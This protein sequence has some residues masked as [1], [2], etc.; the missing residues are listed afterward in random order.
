MTTTNKTMVSLCSALDSY[1]TTLNNRVK[2]E[3]GTYL[4]SLSGMT[5]SKDTPDVQGA[6]VALN[7]Q[8]VRGNVSSSKLNFDDNFRLS[9]VALINNVIQTARL[10]NNGTPESDVEVANYLRDLIVLSFQKRAI[11]ANLGGGER[12]LSYWL[13]IRLHEDF[14][15]TMET[16]LEEMPNYGSWLDLKKMYEI[17]SEDIKKLGGIDREKRMSRICLNKKIVSIWVTQCQLDE[18]T[19][20]SKVKTQMDSENMTLSLNFKWIPKPKSA[21]DRKYKVA[22]QIAKGLYPSLYEVNKHQAVKKYRK[23]STRG[24]AAINTT[25]RLMTS[26]QFSK[27]NFRLVPGRCLNKFHRAWMD[28]DKN[29][30]RRHKGNVDRDQCIENYMAFLELVKTGKVSAKGK[31]MFIHEIVREVR[32]SGGADRIRISDPERYTLLEAQ[33]RDHVESFREFTDVSGL[34]DSVFMADV[35]GSMDGDPL[36]VAVGVTVVGSSITTGPYRNKAITFESQPR[37]ITLEYPTS[38]TVW[39]DGF[40]GYSSRQFPIGN[41]WDSSRVG[42]ELDYLEKITVLVHAGWGGSTNFLGAVNLVYQ[43]AQIAGCSMPKRIICITDMQWDA[44][45]Q[46]HSVSNIVMTKMGDRLKKVPDIRGSFLTSIE[47]LKSYF[48]SQ[49]MELPE[50][51]VWN[52]RGNQSSNGCVAA[53]DTEGVQMISGFSVAMLKLFLTEGSFGDMVTGKATSWDTLRCL[54]DDENYDK[55]RQI[56]SVVG[57]KEFASLS[58]QSS[59]NV[60]S[61]ESNVDQS[62]DNSFEWVDNL[63]ETQLKT[64]LKKCFSTGKV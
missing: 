23:L 15:K 28:V 41:S 50:F 9:K 37:W 11:R 55:V 22:Y 30:N 63:D 52:V 5:E 6:L 54:L 64:L 26:R 3:K 8:L 56:V 35:S 47:H 16:L 53:A 12:T 44:A 20:D 32:R 29:G 57:E 19:L 36:D 45:D 24:N 51:I 7:T 48:S 34:D 31:A 1:S 49:N 38:S 40:N 59:N 61:D 18:I 58:P 39:M 10:M 21:L 25:E 33:F 14:P 17:C 46:T 2:G 60:N 42:K 13:F 4:H 27:I 62:R 43:C